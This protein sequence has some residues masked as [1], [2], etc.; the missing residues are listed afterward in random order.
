MTIEIIKQSSG[1]KADELRNRMIELVNEYSNI[2]TGYEMI[3]VIDVVREDCHN[4]IQAMDE[5]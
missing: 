4:S 3:G 5:E 1:E 2:L